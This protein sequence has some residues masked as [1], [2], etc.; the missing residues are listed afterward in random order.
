MQQLVLDLLPP[1][2][3]S[4]D[5][6]V[7]G[8]NAEALAALQAWLAD[9]APP[10]TCLLLWGE[11]RSGR[12]HLLRAA[13]A[14]RPTALATPPAA[15]AVDGAASTDLAGLDDLPEGIALLVADNVD[16]LDETG[17]VRLF[18][19]FNRLKM[20]GGGLLA[21]ASQPPAALAVREDLRT[22]LGSGLIYRLTPLSDA[23]KITALAAR[24]ARLG[25]ALPAGALDYLLG[26][27]PRD[28]ASLTAIIDALNRFT[29][30]HKRPVTLPLL[31]TLI[32]R[33]AAET[34]AAAGPSPSCTA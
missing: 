14:G 15:L 33:D 29:L 20:R 13:L 30:E 9:P 11:A 21:A 4:F 17:Q 16:A 19:A 18:N 3:P 22:R 32:Q 12:S 24:A 8:R 31:R 10:T 7:A 26:H 34:A 2:A 27:A 6:Y 23:E 25:L 5:N 28:M 1:P